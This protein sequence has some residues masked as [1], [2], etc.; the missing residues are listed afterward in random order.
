MRDCRRGEQ[1]YIAPALERGEHA[2][3][4]LESLLLVVH[5]SCS[6]RSIATHSNPHLTYGSPRHPTEGR[7]G[8]RVV[9]A[10]SKPV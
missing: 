4:S 3:H 7:G 1:P 10:A 6:Q 8:D 9:V 5:L 2:H